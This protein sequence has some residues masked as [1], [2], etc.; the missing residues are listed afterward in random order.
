MVLIGA[1]R[2]LAFGGYVL[3]LTLTFARLCLSFALLAPCF[4][5]TTRIFDRQGK[6]GDWGTL[7][8]CQD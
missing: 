8:R 1:F 3:F 2:F 6:D 4:E 5:V 7:T